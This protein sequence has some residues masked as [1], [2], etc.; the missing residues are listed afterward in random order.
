MKAASQNMLDSVSI[1]ESGFEKA[2]DA[3]KGMTITIQK[4][5]AEAECS[6]SFGSV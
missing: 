3:N 4:A 2:L 1:L 5:N 6:P